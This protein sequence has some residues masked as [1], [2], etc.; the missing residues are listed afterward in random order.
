MTR[1]CHAASDYRHT[2]RKW[3]HGTAWI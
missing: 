2:T 3:S 1:T